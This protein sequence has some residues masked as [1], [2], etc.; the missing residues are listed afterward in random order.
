MATY[1][2]RRRERAAKRLKT[3]E[4]RERI[5]AMRVEFTVADVVNP[6]THHDDVARRS[7]AWHRVDDHEC[8]TAVEQV[9][10]EVHPPDA[11]IDHTN[12][13]GQ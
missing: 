6:N 4:H 8:G 10:G 5:H 3:A 13:V 7:I 11:V 1:D 9:V 12:V 2:I